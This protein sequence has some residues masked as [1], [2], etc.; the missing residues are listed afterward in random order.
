MSVDAA[1]IEAE[2]DLAERRHLAAAHLVQDLARLG[3]RGGIVGGGLERRQPRSTPRATPGSNQSTS[4]A[5]SGRRGRTWSS[6]GDARIRISSCGVLVISMQVGH[7]PAERLIEQVVRGLDRAAPCAA[8][9]RL[10][11]AARNPRKTEP[12]STVRARHSRRK[13]RSRLVRGKADAIGRRGGAEL[14]RRRIEAR[15][16]DA[17]RRQAFVIEHRRGRRLA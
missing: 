1:V 4:A 7:R 17:A 9:R 8:E 6:T 14:A 3:I 13:D 15:R 10:R 11:C 2:R 5:R 16:C 12:A